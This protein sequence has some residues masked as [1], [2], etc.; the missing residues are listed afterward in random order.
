MVDQD[1]QSKDN[2]ATSDETCNPE[3]PLEVAIAQMKAMGFE[4]HDGWLSQLIVSKEYDIGK[5]LD[6][7]QYSQQ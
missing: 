7:M 4:D 6:A 1:K 2:G 3:D 5:V